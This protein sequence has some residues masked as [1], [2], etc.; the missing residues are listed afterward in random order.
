MLLNHWR[1][2]EF[3]Q[4]GQVLLVDMSNAE[5]EYITGVWGG[6]PQQSLG[7]E[8]LVRWSRGEAP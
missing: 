7:A 4:G 3:F 2:Q 8:H 1:P 6:A 5:R